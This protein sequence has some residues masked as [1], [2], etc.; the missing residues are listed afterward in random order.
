MC[1]H[2]VLSYLSPDRLAIPDGSVLHLFTLQPSATYRRAAASSAKSPL[3]PPATPPPIV[4]SA[5]IPLKSPI[6]LLRLHSDGR[7]CTAGV[8]DKVIRLHSTLPTFPTTS[9]SSPSFP[10]VVHLRHDRT[11]PVVSCVLSLEP[12]R[13]L[14][15]FED[16]GLHCYNT[17]TGAKVYGLTMDCAILALIPCSSS[18]ASASLTSSIISSPS[19]P[20]TL[21][22]AS[23]TASTSHVIAY[24]ADRT[25]RLLDLHLCRVARY[26]G[27][28]NYMRAVFV[29]DAAGRVA[30]TSGQSVFLWR[31]DTWTCE[32][33]L[34]REEEIAAEQALT[35]SAEAPVPQPWEEE[36]KDRAEVCRPTWN[37]RRG[38][39]AS[40][41]AG[42]ARY[43]S[44]VCPLWSSAWLASGTSEGFIHLWRVAVHCSQRRMVTVRGHRGR[45]THLQYL[46]ERRLL[47]CGTDGAVRLWQL[48][49]RGERGAEEE[50]EVGDR[51]GG[52][53]EWSLRLLF[54]Y[55]VQSTEGWC[56]TASFVPGD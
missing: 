7:L 17:R 41:P 44:F 50:G 52:E 14:V 30:I 20:L 32:R 38:P 15:G 56:G 31:L 8:K 21:A 55:D 47:S 6:S 36:K 2:R 27:C 5:S 46:R 45:V 24:T 16:G 3:L 19:S 34:D 48:S 29:L 18:Y 11:T 37:D 26:I 1:V 13:L 42:P 43:P 12:S 35:L 23:T 28:I 9:S 22:S 4:L 33:T 40:P 39:P 10:S 51:E 53:G 49:V 54:Q 25:F